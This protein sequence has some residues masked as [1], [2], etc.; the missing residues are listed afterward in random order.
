MSGQWNEES[1][2]PPRLHVRAMGDAR[3]EPPLER[4][5]RSADRATE[6]ARLHDEEILQAL[7]AAS[8]E[9][10]P[11]LA[12]VLATEALNRHRRLVARLWAVAV[13]YTLLFALGTLLVL[14]AAASG[15]GLEPHEGWIVWFALF[16]PPIAAGV[17]AYAWRLRRILARARA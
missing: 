15:A 12:N 11:Y 6:M 8:K 17:A 10:D 2:L 7:G 4:L 3:F 9:S 1:V 16:A 14:S 5:R 13:A